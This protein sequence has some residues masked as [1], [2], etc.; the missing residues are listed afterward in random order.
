MTN[1]V[2]SKGGTSVT[3]HTVQATEDYS[4]KLTYIRPPQTSQQQ[5]NGPKTVKVADLLIITHTLV[6]RGH[7]TA[8]SSKTAKEV[9]DDLKTIFN[10]AGTDGGS[11]NVTYDGDSLNMYPE[12]MTLIQNPSR[13]FDST[14][15]SIIQ[16]DVQLTLVEGTKV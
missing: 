7:I 16:Y 12:K 14:D 10:G 6:V 5:S 8:T 4:N 15:T 13:N 9:K 11:A 3:L 2:I 1:I